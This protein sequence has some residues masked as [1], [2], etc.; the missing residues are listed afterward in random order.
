MEHFHPPRRSPALIAFSALFSAIAITVRDTGEEVPGQMREKLF[1]P[2][3]TGKAKGTGLG[4]AVVKRIAEAPGGSIEF[5][6]GEGKGT[7]FTVIEP[8]GN[9]AASGPT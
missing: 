2:L 5:E 7:T 1:S 9:E 8:R 4:L 6:T 3:T